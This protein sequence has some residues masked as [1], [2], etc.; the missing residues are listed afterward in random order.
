M[1]RKENQEE[2]RGDNTKGGERGTWKASLWGEILGRGGGTEAK[3]KYTYS[4]LFWIW[5]LQAT[6]KF[7][8]NINNLRYSFSLHFVG[9]S[10]KSLRC[11]FV[12]CPLIMKEP[13]RKTYTKHIYTYMPSKP[14]IKSTLLLCT[15]CPEKSQALIF[16]LM[17]CKDVHR[18]FHPIHEE[19][20]SFQVE[21]LGNRVWN[22][23][24]LE[25]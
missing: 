21:K 2:H 25:L 12:F 15:L 3:C 5:I 16:L 6:L 14:K 8:L 9:V 23:I 22:A 11:M 20:S 17:F 18:F 7:L 24:Y 1:G 10:K 4:Q 19:I 13:R